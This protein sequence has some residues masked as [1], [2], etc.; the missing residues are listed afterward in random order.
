MEIRRVIP[1]TA[2]LL[3]LAFALGSLSRSQAGGSLL[4]QSYWL[5]YLV[6]VG[7]LIVLGLMAALLFYIIRHWRDLS[8]G[9]GSRRATG[10]RKTRSWKSRIIFVGMWA[11]AFAVLAFRRQGTAVNKTLDDFRE[12][13]VGRNASLPD[14]LQIGGD[15]AP[16][17]NFIQLEWFTGLFVVLLLVCGF[18]LVQSFRVS[19]RETAN[20]GTL[21]PGSRIVG[22]QAVE[23]A[24]KLV[25][26]TA[27]D[28]RSRII[29]CYEQLISSVPRLG[30]SISPDLTARQLED[31]I[32][33]TFALNGTAIHDLT[34]V[35]EE[36]RY[37]V[38]DLTE[39]DA[40][41]ALTYL[42]SISAELHDQIE[43]EL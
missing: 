9:I 28:P 29:A 15:L 3:F 38:H 24:M 21:F 12:Q 23:H 8:E 19:L 1:Y 10:R 13:I 11:I 30:A 5:L 17:S 18:V 32:R 22:L 42:K 14:P 2:G 25:D 7:P 31:S 43:T 37:S 35:F 4:F 33:S 6:Y 40:S 41:N 26:N 34:G 39:N 20:M 27:L 16:V 36:A